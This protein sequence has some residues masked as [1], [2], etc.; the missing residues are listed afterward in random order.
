M[1]SYNVP[2]SCLILG[3]N[4][5]RAHEWLGMTG[6]TVF[7]NLS[8]EGLEIDFLKKKLSKFVLKAFDLTVWILFSPCVLITC[9]NIS[10]EIAVT[11]F[12]CAP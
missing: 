8:A 9:Q 1:W 6:E 7:I 2:C 4:V 3:K 10:V 5:F 11:G 12:P